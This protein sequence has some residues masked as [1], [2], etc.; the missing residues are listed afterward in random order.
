MK[1]NYN[2]F[3]DRIIDSIKSTNY[4]ETDITKN[5]QVLYTENNKMLREMKD[6][7]NRYIL[8]LEESI[9]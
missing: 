5:Q 6:E 8:L 4:L 9:I 2:F 3:K 1:K 7:I